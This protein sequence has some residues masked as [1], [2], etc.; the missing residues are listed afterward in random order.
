MGL[1]GAVGVPAQDRHP[2]VECGGH[3]LEEGV[4]D[5][6]ALEEG[7]PVAKRRS[8]QVASWKMIPTV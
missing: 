5:R 1:A 3:R 2:S 6:F 8:I 4:T 7:K